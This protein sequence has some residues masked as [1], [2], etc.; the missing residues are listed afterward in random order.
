MCG[1]V[2]ISIEEAKGLDAIEMQGTYLLR[3]EWIKETLESKDF[4]KFVL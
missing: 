3:V 1:R 2:R 4:E